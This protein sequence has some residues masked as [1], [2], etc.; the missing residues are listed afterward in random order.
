VLAATLLQPAVSQADDALATGAVQPLV[1]DQWT[2]PQTGFRIERDAFREY[3][4][5]RGG[6][7]TFGYPVSRDFPFLGCTS[8][9]FQRE[10]M[11]Q[12]AGQGVTTL[13]LL[14]ADLLPYTRINGSTFPA[15]DAAVIDQA[16][17]VGQADYG[18][19][20]MSFVR[21]VAPDQLGGDPVRLWST[22][23][24]TVTFQDA[25]PSGS[26]DA[27]LLPLINLEMW[28]MPT[29][30]PQPDPNNGGFIYQR[31]QRGIMHFD[32]GCGCTQGLLLADYLKAIITGDDLPGDLA[33]QAQSSPLFRS[34][35]DRPAPPGTDYRGAF[36]PAGSPV[37]GRPLQAPAPAPAAAPNVASAPAPV[38][39]GGATVGAAAVGPAA[40]PAATP[41]PFKVA[42]PRPGGQFIYNT[43]IADL[44]STRE[45]TAAGFTHMSAYAAWKKVEPSRGT[46][47]FKTTNQYG[48]TTANDLTNI[49]NAAKSSGM[50]VVLRLD[51]PPDWA[52]GKVYCLNPADV[53]D[54]V[55]QVVSYGKG[56]IAFVEVFNEMNLPY[57]WG[58]S[59]VDPAKYVQIL[60]GA[61]RGAKRADSGVRV[62]VAAVSQRTGGL[63]GTMEDVDW[64]KGFYA[65][66]GKSYY[67]VMGM[68]AYLGNFAPETDGATCS[69]LC[70]R[71]VELYRAVM[72]ANGEGGKPALITEMGTLESS[73]SDLG[74]YNWMK[75]DPDERADYLVRAV[76]IANGNYPWLLG[77][78]V[79]NLD[80]AAVPWN[81]SNSAM[82]WFSLLNPGKTPRQAYTRFKD[83]RHNGTLP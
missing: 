20:A 33:A 44:A 17:A 72:E 41:A 55:Y 51:E 46:Y 63:F 42:P 32:R 1:D 22:F 31:F 56:T 7:R 79:F 53:E 26:G 36:T 75:L 82:Y 4:L 68:H 14:D 57:E 38:S 34:A 9:F 78:T 37:A 43:L 54:F 24:T 73:G 50:K 71:N 25:F 18:P 62:V 3:F 59:P 23:A 29:S 49:V 80:F 65:A 52:C 69:P 13:N 83:A 47:V 66:G 30:L 58:T 11:Q 39:T 5:L 45:A 21:R 77:A 40:T 27:G 28:G 48:Q 10:V 81:S 12:C 67:D 19:L 15:A 61:Y 35:A 6:V 60:A 2:F 8:Q 74:P 16:P 76:Q 64:L 70:F